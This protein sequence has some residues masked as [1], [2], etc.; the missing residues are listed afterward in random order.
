MANDYDPLH[1]TDAGIFG[2]LV[3]QWATDSA[4]RPKTLKEFKEVTANCLVVP[5]RIEED[6]TYIQWTTTNL[7]MRLPSR[8]LL[9]RSLEKF[10]GGTQSAYPLEPFYKDLIDGKI[11]NLDGLYC[12][13]ADYTKSQCG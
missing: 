6:P 11:T 8:V 5:D 7:I 1:L 13:V 10:G 9:Q 3:A 12:R 2:R 4:S